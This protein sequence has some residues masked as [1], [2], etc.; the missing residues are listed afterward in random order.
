MSKIFKN[1]VL[2]VVFTTLIL[3]VFSQKNEDIKR[4]DKEYYEKVTKGVDYTENIKER[5]IKE[6]KIPNI[7]MPNLGNWTVVGELLKVIAIITLV[8]VLA[9]FIYTIFEE[10]YGGANKAIKKYKN[11]LIENLEQHIHEVDLH[12]FLAEALKNNDF[13]LAVRIYYLIIIKQLSDSK[14]INWKKQKTNGEYVSELFGSNYFP[15]FKDSTLIFERI[16]YGDIEI[17]KQRYE[18]V[19]GKYKQFLNKLPKTIN[20]EAK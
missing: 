20:S 13:K 12:Q 11:V 1:M 8:L 3:S 14:L 15:D 6:P 17:D 10:N 4:Y 2:M 9:Y 5:E 16:W 7:N 18:N 19:A